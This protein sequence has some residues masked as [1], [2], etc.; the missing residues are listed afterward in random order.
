M[1]DENGA[2]KRVIRRADRSGKGRPQAR[3]EI[4][5]RNAP[6][7]RR[8]ARGDQYA[9]LARQT[10]V[11]EVQEGELGGAIGIVDRD[12]MAALGNMARYSVSWQPEKP[13]RQANQV[14]QCRNRLNVNEFSQLFKR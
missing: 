8:P 13:Q 5:Q 14:F 2:K 10:G 12:P 7:P 1:L 9:A 3:A 4:V 6:E 11:V